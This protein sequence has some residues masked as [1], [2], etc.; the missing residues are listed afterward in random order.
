MNIGILNH[1][2]SRIFFF[3]MLLLFGTWS[4]AEEKQS[5]YPSAESSQESDSSVSET[6]VVSVLYDDIDKD[7]IDLLI[8]WIRQ[9]FSTIGFDD[10]VE[11]THQSVEEAGIKTFL[12]S[13]A[14][15][16]VTQ[17]DT[18]LGNAYAFIETH[19]AEPLMMTLDIRKETSMF[20][21]SLFPSKADVFE[22]TWNYETLKETIETFI[23]PELAY[24][25]TSEC[26][27]SY[28]EEDLESES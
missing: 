1:G 7:T 4:H 21:L 24:I 3:F 6:A 25:I 20:D 26:G 9:G 14:I 10:A 11:F 5:T 16:L 23:A 22:T 8:S 15:L 18:G 13:N 17:S 28:T 27:C 19:K 2:I 12:E